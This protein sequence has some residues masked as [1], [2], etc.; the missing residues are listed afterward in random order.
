MCVCVQE[1]AYTKHVKP[2][3]PLVAV[4]M[5]ERGGGS[6]VLNDRCRQERDETCR[7]SVVT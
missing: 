1:F 2:H 5:C 6:P 7:Q 3:P 4:R